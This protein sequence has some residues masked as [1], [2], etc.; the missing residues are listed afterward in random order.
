MENLSSEVENEEMT[1]VR[2]DGSVCLL[3]VKSPV[4]LSEDIVGELSERDRKGCEILMCETERKSSE[5]GV[6]VHAS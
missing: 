3:Q 1:G 2:L 5:E 6:D 4:L